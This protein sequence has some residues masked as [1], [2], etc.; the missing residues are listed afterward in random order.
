MPVISPM[1]LPGTVL[2]AADLDTH[3]RY[4]PANP[5]DSLE[6]LSGGLTS[7]NAAATNI[8]APLWQPGAFALGRYTPIESWQFAYGKQLNTAGSGNTLS[9]RVTLAYG[10]S[11]FL[12]WNAIVVIGYQAMCQHDATLWDTGGTPRPEYWDLDVAYD[13][14]LRGGLYAKLPHGRSTTSLPT[15]SPPVPDPGQHDEERWRYV[16]RFQILD[17]SLGYKGRHHVVIS[18][19]ASLYAD[20]TKTA[21]IVIP[22][23]SVFVGAL[24]T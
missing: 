20:D 24:R 15:T 12:P 22:S 6:I 9:T 19:W 11:F 7:A 13:G 1:V 5:P 17:G 8:K 4:N 21:K 14:V 3:G 23:G 16:S 10:M 2:N 18:A